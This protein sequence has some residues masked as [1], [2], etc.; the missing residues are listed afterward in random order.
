MSGVIKTYPMTLPEWHD[1]EPVAQELY[2]PFAQELAAAEESL[3]QKRRKLVLARETEILA[4]QQ[5]RREID[6]WTVRLRSSERRLSA[7]NAELG[8]V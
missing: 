2:A 3:A 1:S 4:V 6:T 8:D 7:L 5:Y